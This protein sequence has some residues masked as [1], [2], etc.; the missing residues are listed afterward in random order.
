MA[1][2][3]GSVHDQDSKQPVSG[4]ILRFYALPYNKLVETKISDSSGR[5]S[6]LVGPGEFYLTVEKKGYIKTESSPIKIADPSGTSI[7][8]SLPM[9]L[10]Q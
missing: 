1:K 3:F 5:Y 8:A 7:N 10:E 6:F 2:S 9:K 4:A